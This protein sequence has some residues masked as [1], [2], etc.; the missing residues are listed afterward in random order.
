MT[1]NP[2]PT[3]AQVEALLRVF[4]AGYLSGFASSL[5]AGSVDETVARAAA[6][7][8]TASIYRDPIARNQVAD[9][10][11]AAYR[12]EPGSGGKLSVPMCGCGYSHDHGRHQGDEP[13]AEPGGDL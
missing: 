6:V 7:H 4:L 2:E 9:E 1:T 8:V 12:G 11:V 13:V 5:V 10:A 3:S